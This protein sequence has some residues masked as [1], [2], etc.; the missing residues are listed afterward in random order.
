MEAP[1]VRISLEYDHEDEFPFVEV[2]TVLWEVMRYP[3]EGLYGQAEA[4]AKA[5]A[6]VARN[7]PLLRVI[8][9]T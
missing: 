2:N 8:D 5:K 3:Y 1:H 4:V 9:L 7:W 6:W